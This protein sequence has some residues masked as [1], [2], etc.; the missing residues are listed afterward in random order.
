MFRHFAMLTGCVTFARSPQK[1][2]KTAKVLYIPRCP[3]DVRDD[4]RWGPHNNSFV[5]GRDF[6]M[7]VRLLAIVPAF[8]CLATAAS[9]ADRPDVKG[10]YLLADYPA[11]SVQPG[12]TTNIPL[13]L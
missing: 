3:T 4:R 8:L 11:V 12:T 7:R 13:K 2:P 5:R 9:A 1:I 6:A 10:L